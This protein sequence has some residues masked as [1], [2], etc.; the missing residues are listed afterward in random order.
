[1]FIKYTIEY[2]QSVE[3]IPLIVVKNKKSYNNKNKYYKKVWEITNKNALLLNNIKQ[4]GFK[5]FHI[6]HIVPISYGL[7]HNIKEELIG[8]LE[9]IRLIYYKDNMKKGKTITNDAKELLKL[10]N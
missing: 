2:L 4:R 6:D 7:K 3:E 10:W 9:N 5:T 8:S 1:M